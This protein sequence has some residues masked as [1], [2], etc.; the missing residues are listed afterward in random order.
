MTLSGTAMSPSAKTRWTP[1][2][3]VGPFFSSKTKWNRFSAAVARRRRRDDV[4]DGWLR[5]SVATAAAGAEARERGATQSGRA[6]WRRNGCI[7]GIAGPP[8]RP[9]TLPRP[10][11][12]RRLKPVAAVLRR[13]CA[14]GAGAA[15]PAR[16]RPRTRASP[17]RR[18]ASARGGR[19]A[20]ARCSGGRARLRTTPR[21]SRPSAV[22]KG[23]G[24]A[25]STAR[26]NP[27]S[28]RP[29]C[30]RRNAS[31]TSAQRSAS[32]LATGVLRREPARAQERE[33]LELAAGMVGPLVR[34]A[35]RL[36][37]EGAVEAGHVRHLA[38]LPERV[39]LVAALVRR[40]LDLAAEQARLRGRDRLRRCARQPPRAAQRARRGRPGAA[41]RPPRARRPPRAV[42]ADGGA[43]PS[44]SSRHSGD[45]GDL[46]AR[47]RRRPR[48]R[49]RRQA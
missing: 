25:F 10:N 40:H 35:V 39:V 41:P 34:G 1:V 29:A 11:P 15:S 37:A 27:G 33:E 31:S 4:L 8:V 3:E 38:G 36:G 28:Q 13:A 42:S 30:S 48:S 21:P 7:E 14:S 49:A 16:C 46:G 44:E 43:R 23:S 19:A 47:R 45:G 17:P 24:A 22:W 32:S 5:L 18:T 12:R 20:P 26:K 9:T 6:A 2:V